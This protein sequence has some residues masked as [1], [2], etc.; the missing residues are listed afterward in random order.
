MEPH[1]S[2][3]AQHD[4]PHTSQQDGRYRQAKSRL[5]GAEPRRLALAFAFAEEAVAADPLG[6]NAKS[7]LD[8]CHIALYV[9][10][11]VMS[12]NSA[13]YRCNRSTDGPEASVI[14]HGLT[15]ITRIDSIT[16]SRSPGRRGPLQALRSAPPAALQDE[17]L[18]A[19]RVLEDLASKQVNLRFEIDHETNRVHVQMLNSDGELIREIPAK[20]LLDLLSGGSPLID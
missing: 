13:D 5:N 20:N 11:P 19:G 3:R 8:R 7:L 12:C 17:Y 4:E 18:A 16:R 15:P 6:G 10:V 2:A 1:E 9:I 14:E